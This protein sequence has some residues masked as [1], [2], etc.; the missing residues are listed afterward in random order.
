MK[1]LTSILGLLFLGALALSGQR[2]TPDTPVREFLL[3]MFGPDGYKVWDLRGREGRYVAPNEIIVSGMTLRTFGSKD[4]A[5]PE[6]II[7]SPIATINPEESTAE[8]E[9]L[10][11]IQDTEGHY[12]I[13]G[14]NWKWEGR[15][16]KITIR[17]EARVVFRQSLGSILD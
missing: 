7:Q 13:I 6:T 14:R 12:S 17:A 16:N 1:Q 10:L 8:G 2:M 11:Q 3:P 5:N 15:E 4:P 9:D